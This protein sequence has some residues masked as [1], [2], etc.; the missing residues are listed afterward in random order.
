MELQTGLKVF[1]DKTLALMD[2]TSMILH[3]KYKQQPRVNLTSAEQI[4]ELLNQEQIFIE[5]LFT[6]TK[7][8]IYQILQQ[9]IQRNN[10]KVITT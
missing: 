9:N 6:K 3:R 8:E 4:K 7:Q 10:A 2:Y 5:K 1:K